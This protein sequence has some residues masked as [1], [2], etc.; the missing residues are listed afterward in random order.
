MAVA[1][2]QFGALLHQ[3]EF[4]LHRGDI[5]AV[6]QWTM[7]K[8]EHTRDDMWVHIP[9]RPSIFNHHAYLDADVYPEGAADVTGYWAEG[10]ILGGVVV[11]DRGAERGPDGIPVEDPPNVYFHPDRHR[12]TMRVTQLLDHQQQALVDFLL[13][14]PD[15]AG[16]QCP[17]PI[18]V[19]DRNR[20]RVDAFVAHTHHLLFRDV[21]ERRP[22]LVSDIYHQLRRPQSQV[23]YPQMAVEMLAVNK[24]LGIEPAGKWKRY[25]D[26]DED[27]PDGPTKRILDE[28]RDRCGH[29]KKAKLGD[30]GGGETGEEKEGVEE[31]REE[32]EEAE[33]EAEE[34]GKKKEEGVKESKPVKVDTVKSLQHFLSGKEEKEESEEE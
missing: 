6:T 18:L 29:E 17:L 1:L 16:V 20:V 5:E 12:L 2:H 9:P 31:K 30:E 24:R 3:F 15:A 28:Y 25:L 23:D 26:G 33:E 8:P 19:D 32:E 7:A 21:W 34:K 27:L 13:A 4:R 11:F 14:E 10:R 22:L